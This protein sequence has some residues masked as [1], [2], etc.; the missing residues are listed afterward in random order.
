MKRFIV[1]LG[2][3]FLAAVFLFGRSP[4]FVGKP[5]DKGFVAI[6]DGKTLDGWH[7]SAKTGH[8]GAS[9]HK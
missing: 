4:G 3:G 6:F 7:V 9:K 2:T 5:D 8:S 1:F